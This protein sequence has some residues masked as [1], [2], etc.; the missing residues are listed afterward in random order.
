MVRSKGRKGGGWEQ[1][2]PLL[3][4]LLVLL[5]G[6]ST[7]FKYNVTEP[8]PEGIDVNIVKVYYDRHGAFEEIDLGDSLSYNQPHI[9]VH[10]PDP[11]NLIIE[12][13][14]NPSNIHDTDADVGVAISRGIVDQF[15][16]VKSKTYDDSKYSM[17]K[18]AGKLIEWQGTRRINATYN[19]TIIRRA[20]VVVADFYVNIWAV[21]GSGDDPAHNIGI[22]FM[23]KGVNWQQLV[24]LPPTSTTSTTRSPSL[25]ERYNVVTLPSGKAVLVEQKGA[26]IPIMAFVKE[27]YDWVW[28]TDGK[29]Y[30]SGLPASGAADNVVLSPSNVGAEL[31]L[32]TEPDNNYRFYTDITPYDYISP[33]YLAGWSPDW[34][35]PSK[36]YFQIY[37]NTLDPYNDCSFSIGDWG[38]NCLIWYPSTLFKIRVVALAVGEFTYVWNT[39]NA[40]SV[41][42]TY[43]PHTPTSVPTGGHSSFE[44]FLKWLNSPQGRF[45]GLLLIGVAVL[46]ILA[47]TGVLNTLL[48]AWLAKR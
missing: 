33:D 39:E 44:S 29:K 48:I 37:I 8:G 9:A 42:W 22:W 2:I 26:F 47:A 38:V 43:K 27:Y 23:I 19:E 7:L 12:Y 32:F 1:L 10:D 36:A 21:P 14:A 13:R 41:S 24:G 4:L 34:R 11:K 45:W 18:E 20:R 3:A 5:A 15:A 30:P 35:I 17:I 25:T 6:A 16:G 31:T 28:T 40:E 46:A